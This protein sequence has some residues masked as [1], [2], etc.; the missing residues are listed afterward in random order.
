MICYKVRVWHGF[1]GCGVYF[2]PPLPRPERLDVAPERVHVPVPQRQVHK[3]GGV[4]DEDA[5]HRRVEGE[6]LVRQP[7][8]AREAKGKAALA[9]RGVTLRRAK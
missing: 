8:N 6:A 4:H 1:C 9:V 3:I 2:S 7:A 5:L